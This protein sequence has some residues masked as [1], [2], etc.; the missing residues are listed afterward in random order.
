[1]LTRVVEEQCSRLREDEDPCSAVEV[2]GV[3]F[4]SLGTTSEKSDFP[5]VKL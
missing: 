1:M 2:L 3:A 4:T 5:K